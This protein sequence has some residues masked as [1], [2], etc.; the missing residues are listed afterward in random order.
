MTRSMRPC[1]GKSLAER[2]GNPPPYYH[3]DDFGPFPSETQQS[4]LTLVLPETLLQERKASNLPRTFLHWETFCWGGEQRYS[5]PRIENFL[6]NDHSGNE[7]NTDT[8]FKGGYSSRC[9]QTL[10]SERWRDASTNEAFQQLTLEILGYRICWPRRVCQDYWRRLLLCWPFS[11]WPR[12]LKEYTS[13]LIRRCDK[14]G[15][16]FNLVD[17]KGIANVE[18]ILNTR[19]WKTLGDKSPN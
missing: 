14:K 15:T 10:A 18:Y 19:G 2:I 9:T 8:D 5:H 4:H 6:L 16:D 7:T 3:E 1:P 11:S 12:G 17:D 13:G